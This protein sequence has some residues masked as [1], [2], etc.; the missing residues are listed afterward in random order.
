[1]DFIDQDKN[2]NLSNS[3]HIFHQNVRGLRRRRRRRRRR[4][5]YYA[6]VK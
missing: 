6:L 2:E 3:F 1:L 4:R 5:S